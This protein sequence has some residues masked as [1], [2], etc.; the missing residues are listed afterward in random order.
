MPAVEPQSVDTPET[1]MISRRRMI[2]SILAGGAMAAAPVL[3][4]RASADSGSTAT[5]VAQP[6][7]SDADNS[8]L[9]ALLSQESR[10]VATY[11]AALGASLSKD[12]IAALELIRDNHLAYVH[13]IK[14]YLGT[15]FTA[16]SNA[17]LASPAGNLAAVANALAALED[18]TL[19]LHLGAMASLAAK[20]SSTLIASIITMEA[21][22]STALAIVAGN[23]PTA[24]ASR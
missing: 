6:E 11:N 24:A 12:D 21:R 3:V 5:T 1:N 16:P 23:A 18:Q 19:N 2:T 9:N 17:P 15:S 14:G 13:A 4:G 7:R 8:V 10:M 20:D 22:H